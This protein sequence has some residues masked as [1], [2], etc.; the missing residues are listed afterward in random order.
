MDLS[1][2]FLRFYVLRNPIRMKTVRRQHHVPLAD[3]LEPRRL[4]AAF[5]VLVFSKTEGFRHTSIDEGIDAI[6]DLGAANDFTVTA[7]EDAS[8]I[9]TANLAQYEAL[10]FLSTTGD[11]LNN[12]QQA[13][14]ESYIAAGGGW[15]GI[16][17]A[18]DAEYD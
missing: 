15:V 11:F 2:T 3:F 10:V 13:A 18:A 14:L 1:L 8:A 17:A 16:H 4:F 5:D 7:T 6:Q 9:S 12:T